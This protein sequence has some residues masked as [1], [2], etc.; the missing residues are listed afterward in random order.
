M[1]SNAPRAH[2]KDID[3]LRAVAVVLVVLFHMSFPGFESG[4]VGVDI[5]FVLSG[6]LITGILARELDETGSIDLLR[7][8]SRRIRRL[9]PAGSVVIAAVLGFS[10]AFSSPLS[11]NQTS[12]TARSAV[13]YYSNYYFAGEESDYFGSDTEGNPLLHFWSLSVEEQYY[14]VWPLVF[15]AV[16]FWATRSK[17]TKSRTVLLSAITLVI[18]ISFVHSYLLSAE[19]SAGAYY[20]TT[21]RAWEFAVGALVAVLVRKRPNVLASSVRSISAIA[22]LGLL[23]VSLIALDFAPFPAPAGLLPVA[24]TILFLW[25]EVPETTL[26]GR[27]MALSPVQ[28]LGRLSY[29][30]YLWHWPFLVLGQQYLQSTTPITRI[31][32]VGLS[33]VAA[34][35]THHLVENPLRYS[36]QLKTK[37]RSYAF[38]LL[39]IV[40]GFAGAFAL[41]SAAEAK[42]AEPELAALQ[43]LRQPWYDEATRDFAC[44]SSDVELLQQNCTFGTVDSSTNVLLLGDSNA[45][46]WLPTLTTLGEQN[47]FSVTLRVRGGCPAPAVV[48]TGT[49]DPATC[50]NLQSETSTLISEL[51]PD[52]IV[53]SNTGNYA[54]EMLGNDGA[55]LSDEGR[56]LLWMEKTAELLDEIDQYPI[57]WIKPIPT[58]SYDPVDCLS[59][60][61]ESECT[62]PIGPAT[63]SA[64]RQ[65]S[66]TE[67]AI[68]LRGTPDSIVTFDP[69]TTLCNETDCPLVIDGVYVYR[70][71]THLSAPMADY[72]APQ[73]DA[74]IQEL[75]IY[76]AS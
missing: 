55:F 6:F 50:S 13:L 54:T 33:L 65:G 25:A 59:S 26:L 37:T 18:A 5:F 17:S 76:N 63:N 49:I 21:S 39:T 71:N 31:A 4:F 60:K 72:F 35:A 22:G 73:I 58:F 11:W 61:S 8:W 68:N 47:N 56:R 75:G 53:I 46:H 32:L 74:R 10:W 29:S 15:A 20:L 7:F 48:A 64:S 24:G 45:E 52:L 67:E 27:L 14:L 12:D 23:A 28:Y 43:D 42:L 3:A 9:L 41:T 34:V 19:G 51:D 62:N 16:G 57:L 69:L 70:D 2:R 36:S 44:A 38:G 40:F 30:W 1:K 66:W